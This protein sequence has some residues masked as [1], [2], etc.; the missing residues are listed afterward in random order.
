MLSRAIALIALCLWSAGATAQDRDAQKIISDQMAA[1]A[2]GDMDMAFTYASPG[3]QSQFGSA[4]TFGQMVEQGYPMV[5]R[6]AEVL[7]LDD[8]T[9]G[10]ALVQRVM[11]TDQGGRVHVLDYYM[12]ADGSGLRIGGVRIVPSPG[13]GA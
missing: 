4:Q 8:R 9:E 13:V 5:W 12:Q 2:A 1:F 7:F 3:I 6:P 10:G 11:I